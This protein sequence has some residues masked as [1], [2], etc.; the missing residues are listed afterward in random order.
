ML[1][2][3]DFKSP[4]DPDE[5]TTVQAT[6][7]FFAQKYR[8]DP[9][10]A[11]K[12]DESVLR[13]L[14]LKLRLYG[15]EFDQ[16]SVIPSGDLL[17]QIGA[18]ADLSF[19]VA[20]RGA[21]LFSPS[22]EELEERLGGAPRFGDRI[23][24]FTDVRLARQCSTC[25]AIPV[26]GRRALEDAVIRLYGTRG[27][28]QVGD[29]NLSSFSMAD[30][31]GFLDEPP[32]SLLEIPLV[33]SEELEEPLRLADWLVFSIQ[34]GSQEVY[35]S[36][37]LKLF[38]DRRPDLARDKRIVVFAHDVPYDLDATEISKLDA[39]YGLYSKVAP[40]IDVSAR[41]LFQELPAPGASPVSIPGLGYSLIEATSPDPAQVLSIQVSQAVDDSTPVADNEGF[42]VGDI[43]LLQTGVIVD[44]NNNPVPD[45]TPVDFVV[46]YQS[47]PATAPLRITSFS[48]DGVA[49][50]N[51]ALERVGLLSIQ[52]E[53]GSARTSETL[54][55]NVQ[56]GIEAFATII[57]PTPAPTETS[58]PAN[59]PTARA[60][61]PAPELETTETEQ[62]A[63]DAS[64][65][66][67]DLAFGLL[68]IAFVAGGDYISA[69]SRSEPVATRV[70]RAWILAIGGL[71]GYNYV[72]VG[73]PGSPELI[74]ALGMFV[75]L[76]SAL[77]GGLLA[78]IG[79]EAYA[80]FLH[81]RLT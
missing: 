65:A 71:L 63:S 61:T 13:I 11:E 46:S 62:S 38:L 42:T 58:A 2:L 8:E 15:G 31:A 36:N 67:L 27:A 41:L 34:H 25:E 5:L 22:V 56:E 14:G 68:G 51:L 16:E 75:G 55:L 53:S 49:K 77:S 45:N 3:S 32:P 80:F 66:I 24:F 29:W 39:Y 17:S 64:P 35:G 81:R 6:L 4:E 40:F 10:F 43:V 79:L 47:E 7:A 48:T 78:W 73:M 57:A 50:T 69:R 54:Q 23:V 19:Q 70:R 33:P 37:A 9:A 21:T 76:V 44:F 74:E 18:G 28:G 60:P 59:T 72:A 1:L 52:V 30:L 26:V 20:Q 12:V